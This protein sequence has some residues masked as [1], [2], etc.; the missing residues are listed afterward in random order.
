M[1]CIF[2]L[3]LLLYSVT[4]IKHKLLHNI[5][6]CC[7]FLW[8]NFS[9]FASI[10]YFAFLTVTVCIALSAALYY[11]SVSMELL[12]C[13]CSHQS[14]SCRQ[15]VPGL[16]GTWDY[17]RDCAGWA[18]VLQFHHK[19]MLPQCLACD[20]VWEVV[21]VC[22]CVCVPTG[23]GWGIKYRLWMFCFPLAHR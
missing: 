17:T 18:P 23:A 3:H 20:V 9:H 1:G 19:L 11:T 2:I 7:S 8:F 5:C 21:G 6:S 16:S 10:V 15:T 12:C 22:V 14:K 13:V 4:N